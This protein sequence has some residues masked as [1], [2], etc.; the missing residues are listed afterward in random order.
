MLTAKINFLSLSHTV[1]ASLFKI[2]CIKIKS[3]SVEALFHPYTGPEVES[4]ESFTK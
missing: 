1:S 3:T 2:G 4:T